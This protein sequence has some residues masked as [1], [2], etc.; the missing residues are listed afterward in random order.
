MHRLLVQPALR[1][2]A[3]RHGQ[4]DGDIG[5]DP[6]AAVEDARE[7]LAADAECIRG[8]GNTQQKRWGV[9]GTVTEI[10]LDPTTSG[11]AVQ[12]LSPELHPELHI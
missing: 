2:C 4:A 3:K 12:L 6:G 10:I 5:A 8:L 11:L 9:L 1:G 7:R